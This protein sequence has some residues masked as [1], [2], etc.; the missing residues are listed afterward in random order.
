MSHDYFVHILTGKGRATLYIGV[1]NDLQNRIWQHRNPEHESFTQRYHC[2]I[3]VW[4]EHFGDVHAAIACEKK[5]K[6]WR[7]S[8]KI[9]LIEK[10]NPNWEDLSADWW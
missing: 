2:I 1:T 4:Y 6:G 3:L 7:R 10:Q 5:L 9:A 8:K